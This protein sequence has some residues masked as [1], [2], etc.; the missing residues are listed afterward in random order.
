[1]NFAEI[2]VFYE[3]DSICIVWYSCIFTGFEPRQIGCEIGNFWGKFD[4]SF[5]KL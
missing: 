5:F 1:M 3:S 2:P 4:E